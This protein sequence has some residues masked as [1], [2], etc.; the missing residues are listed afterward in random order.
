MGINL[1]D[2]SEGNIVF[3]DKQSFTRNDLLKKYR[4]D[5]YAKKLLESQIDKAPQQIQEKEQEKKIREDQ[6]K[7]IDNRL[8][9]SEEIF[10]KRNIDPQEEL[11]RLRETYSEEELNKKAQ[12]ISEKK[13]Y[14]VKDNGNHIERITKNTIS[15]EDE[16]ILYAS[17][18]FNKLQAQEMIVKIDNEISKIKNRLE[19]QKEELQKVKDSTEAIEKYF[20]K[21]RLD[22]NKLLDEQAQERKKGQKQAEELN[23]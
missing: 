23:V 18:Q 5:L 16:L 10:K 1:K 19:A 17:N 2:D 3:S 20:K 6:I 21:K 8:K 7:E 4:N 22:I 14:E 11:K 15:E 9:K 12:N 13:T